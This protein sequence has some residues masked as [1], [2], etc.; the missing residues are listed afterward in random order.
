M[1][2]TY[3]HKTENHPSELKSTV[4]VT[5]KKAP[6]DDSIRLLNEMQ[7]EIRESLVSVQVENNLLN[8]SWAVF[9]DRVRCRL[10]LTY[11]I[12]INEDVY[13]DEVTL[14]C[15]N[16]LPESTELRK[17]VIEAIAKTLAER[18]FAENVGTLVSLY[19]KK[20]Q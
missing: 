6:T 5:E 14:E 17:K 1:F 18:C 19:N 7:K 13:T 9:E 2:N 11:K 16:R 3:I 15:F 12:I 4:T 8:F 10:V 20:D